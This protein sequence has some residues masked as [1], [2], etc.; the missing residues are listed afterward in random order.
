MLYKKD[1]KRRHPEKMNKDLSNLVTP[2]MI[3]EFEQNESAG[4]MIRWIGKLTGAHSLVVNQAVH[5]LRRFSAPWNYHWNA[6]SSGVLTNMTVS[7]GAKK[8]QDSIVISV[9]HKT[10]DTHSPGGG[11]GVRPY[12]TCTSMCRPK[13]L[14]FWSS[15]FR[16]G[17]PFQRRFLE[18]GIIFRTHESSSVVTAQHAWCCHQP[19]SRIYKWTSRKCKARCWIQ[20]VMRMRVAKL[21][22]FCL[23]WSLA[24]SALV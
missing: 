12:I 2:D 22:Y 3:N 1:S 19:Y 8:K 13:G 14:W 11:G 17:Y 10:A 18:R 20:L 9:K 23:G 4:S 16:T 15:W 24:K 5:T 6:H 21:T 7:E